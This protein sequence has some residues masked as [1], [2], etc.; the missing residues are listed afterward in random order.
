MSCLIL[1]FT[2]EICDR[3]QGRIQDLA[4]GGGGGGGGGGKIHSEARYIYERRE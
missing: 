3:N 4:M 1:H 2:P